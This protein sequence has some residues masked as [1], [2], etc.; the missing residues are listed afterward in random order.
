MWFTGRKRGEGTVAS[1]HFTYTVHN[2]IGGD[3][4]ILA[5]EDVTGISPA[6]DGATSA[7]YADEMAAALTAAGHTSDV[8][9]FDTQGR[10]APHHL[11]VLS[12]YKAV[13]WETGD[14][15][16]LRAPGQVPGTT[17]KA[18]L[19]IEL[20]VRDYLNEGG[21]LLVSGKY[22]LLRAVGERWRT[23]TTRMRR[24]SRSAPTPDDPVCLPV[25]N[26]FLQY[27]LG[28]YTYIDGGGTD[29]DGATYPLAGRSP[30]PVHRA[31]T[32]TLDDSQDHTA[33]F[34]PTSSFLPP[35]QF[36]WFGPS[37]AP[38]D[39]ARPGAAPFEPHT[40]DWHLY[41][42]QADESYK[43]L[44]RTVDLT[45]ATAGQLRFFTSYETEARLGLHVR[46]GAR[47]RQRRLDDAAGPERPY[48]HRHRPQLPGGW[49]EL[50]PFLDHYQTKRRGVHADRHHRQLERGHRVVGRLGG[51]GGRPVGV[52]RQ[53]GRAVDHLR[54]PTGAPR[55]S[56]VFLDD[57]S[58]HGG[59]L[60]S[61][62]RR[63]RRT[64]AAGRWPGLRRARAANITDWARSQLAYE[65][66]AVT[67]TPDTVYTGLRAR[68]AAAG[69]RDDFVTR[70]MDHLLGGARTRP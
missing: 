37:S 15:I 48:R 63:S 11:G 42:G 19:D 55:G 40:G 67:V 4:L 2:D 36:P 24:T 1:E 60:P 45:G 6:Q 16:I 22:A 35:A 28:A 43:R 13:V 3:V 58:G 27:W 14:D 53:A 47:G 34:L 65:E 41:S 64:S 8:Y 10:K 33:S 32:R 31:G 59:G 21:K 25:L 50:H 62:R 66:G 29:A 44:T 56:G 46:R 5:A 39:W 54:R 23:S 38:V 9:D 51:V 26:D 52:R 70:S 17:M 57:V 7:K 18:A 49:D 20:S 30:T 68:G 61:P 69:E 12:H